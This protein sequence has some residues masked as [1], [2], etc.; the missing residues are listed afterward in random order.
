MINH[1]TVIVAWQGPFSLDEVLQNKQ[2]ATGL[3]LITGK[4]KHE[5]SADIQYCGITEGT[6][7]RRL[8]DHHKASQ[9]TREQEF[10]LAQVEY[11]NE[12]SRHFLEKAEAIIIYFWKPSL[13]EKKKI[14]PPTPVTL[15][16]KWYKK[17]GSARYRQHPMMKYLD[18]V[19]CWDG[20][21]WRTGNLGVYANE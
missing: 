21:L 15:I 19:L 13:N 8:K 14:F 16:N 6:F 20:E 2:R 11:P 18:D 5:R 4:Q 9:V 1:T 7:Y 12:P 3:Y 17:D 10:W